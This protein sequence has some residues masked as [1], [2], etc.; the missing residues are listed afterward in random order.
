[1][2]PPTAISPIVGTTRR[3]RSLALAPGTIAVATLGAAEVPVAIEIHEDEPV[4]DAAAW[5]H[6]VEAS[7]AVASGRLVV[8]G[9]TDYLPDAKRIAVAPAS[10]R[11]RIS[12][13]GLDTVSEDG[14]EGED[15]YRLQLWPAPE[16]EL[17]ILK[18]R[19]A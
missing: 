15:R 10:Y 11:V 14:L 4:G 17:R 7:I 6:V 13:G 1:M 16:S 5:D 18:Q 9:C 3:R 19:A 8:A 2:R 12:Y